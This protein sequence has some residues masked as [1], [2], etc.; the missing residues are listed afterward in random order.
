M[1]KKTL[2]AATIATISTGALAISTDATVK[3]ATFGA[4]ALASGFVA[5][6]GAALTAPVIVLTAGA[7][8]SKDDT[9]TISLVG[10]EF[11][12]GALSLTQTSE[13]AK[14]SEVTFGLLNSSATEA[15]FRVTTVTA[16]SSS[17]ATLVTNSTIGNTFALTAVVD[18][19]KA[20]NGIKLTSTVNKA[21]VKVTAIAKTSA[22]LVIDTSSTDTTLIGTVK[23]E[24]AFTSS[25]MAAK[26]DVSKERKVFLDATLANITTTYKYN[27]TT[28]ANMI[29]TSTSTK[30]SGSFVGFPGTEVTGLIVDNA[31]AAAVVGVIALDKQSATFANVTDL[32]TAKV[33]TFTVATDETKREVLQASSY[34]ADLT[35]TN[36][37]KTTVIAGVAAGST[38][39]NGASVSFGYAPVNYDGA[40]TTQF[41][42][43]NK[44]SIDGEIT[45]DAFDTNGMNYSA[46]L[47][48]TAEAGKLTKISDADISTAFSLT[49]GT[50]LK[51]TITVNSPTD[52]I[53]VAGYS[54]RGTTG[55]MAISSL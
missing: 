41:E 50:K 37:S 19:P 14:N 51:L 21:E 18:A 54:N 44:G 2:L 24:H 5:N 43:G 35:I 53:S 45:L 22:G 11:D 23:N 17:D 30:I 52:D 25:V 28:Q 36:G 46:I 16:G 29:A 15:T 27:A 49:A 47:P 13:T 1:F 7:E 33:A 31:S 8:Y 6:T 26:I 3:T 9:I 40:V 10:A 48:F 39:L 42:I 34:T 38:T 32:T 55:R 12:A 4:E 20:I